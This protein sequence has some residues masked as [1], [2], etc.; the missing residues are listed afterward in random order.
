MI[1]KSHHFMQI[2]V[3]AVTIASCNAL[4]KAYPCGGQSDGCGEASDPD[5]AK[6]GERFPPE[7]VLCPAQRPWDDDW[8][9][10]CPRA[11]SLTLLFDRTQCYSPTSNVS[12]LYLPDQQSPCNPLPPR[13]HRALLR[14]ERIL[15]CV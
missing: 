15:T 10:S 8:L 9:H 4:G 14:A 6:H 7:L 3:C 11:S 13:A 1:K 2:E 12:I 5:C